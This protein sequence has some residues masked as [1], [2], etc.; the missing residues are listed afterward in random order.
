[1]PVTSFWLPDDLVA[2]FRAVPNKSQLIGRLLRAYF[3]KPSEAD[4]GGPATPEP[5][6]DPERAEG[7]APA[8]PVLAPDRAGR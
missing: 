1:M 5:A 7:A 4:A 8:D 2:R 3:G 6:A